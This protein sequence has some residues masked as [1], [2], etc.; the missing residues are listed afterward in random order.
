MEMHCELFLSYYWSA[1][2][3]HL[4]K[5]YWAYDRYAS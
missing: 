4:Y 3:C 2:V 1:V 5:Y